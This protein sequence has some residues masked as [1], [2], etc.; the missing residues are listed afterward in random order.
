MK[1]E[2]IGKSIQGASHIRKGVEC[3][4]AFRKVELENGTIILAVADGHGSET[5]PFSSTGAKS[6]TNVFC[7]IM[8]EHH[9]KYSENLELLATYLNREGETR[10]AQ[11][12]DSEWKRRI[13][14]QH[15]RLKRTID[16][17]ED[18]TQD[19]QSV[20]KQYGTTLLG[21]MVT[22]TFLFAFQLGDGDIGYVDGNGYE[23]VVEGDKILGV[24]THSLSRESAWEKAISIV[25]RRSPVS[26]SMYMLSS[27]G[28]ANSYKDEASFRATCIDYFNMLNE[29]G[30]AAIRANLPAWLMETSEMGCGDDI[31]L[32]MAYA[33]EQEDTDERETE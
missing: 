28:F 26:P 12:I 33:G 17:L 27:D 8:S 16:V 23:A 15:K 14:K 1:Y 21:L 24:E 6:A 11:A 10:I 32:L 30:V 13:V 18:G 31:T 19:V 3:Q 9:Q 4:D 2:I 7:D 20:Y 22:D 29:H 5:C 25:R